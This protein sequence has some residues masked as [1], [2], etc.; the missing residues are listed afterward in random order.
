MS[1]ML[2]M[3][4]TLVGSGNSRWVLSNDAMKRVALRLRIVFFSF[5]RYAQTRIDHNQLL[6]TCG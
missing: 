6:P 3:I 4:E 1:D 2:M 5:L